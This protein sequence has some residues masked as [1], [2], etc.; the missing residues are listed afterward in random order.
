[1]SVKRASCSFKQT[2]T[3]SELRTGRVPAGA[4]KQHS[5]AYC[6]GNVQ[7]MLTHS[8][9]LLKPADQ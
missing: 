3:V 1:M 9:H 7:C 8:T 2:C 6:N 4:I 5:R